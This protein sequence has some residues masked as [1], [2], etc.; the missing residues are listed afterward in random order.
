MK[1]NKKGWYFCSDNGEFALENPENSSYLYFPLANEAGLMSS[2]TPLLHG[3]IKSGQNSFLMAPVSAEELHNSRAGRNFWL[4]VEGFGAWSAAGHSAAQ[5]CMRFRQEDEEYSRLEAGFLWH[6]MTRVNEKMGLEAEITSFVPTDSNR[7]ELMC[8]TVRN[9]GDK[10]VAFT[11][12]AAIP[13]YGRSA[14]NLRDHRHVTSLLNRIYTQQYGITVKPTLSFDERG[15]R[16]NDTVYFVLGADENG[17]APLG[18]YPDVESFIGEGGS[19][20]WPEAIVSNNRE[21]LGPG[22]E[23]GGFE[24]MGALRFADMLLGPGESKSYVVAVGI[25]ENEC[26]AEEYITEYCTLQGFEH[27]LAECRSYW[28]NK[29]G[30]LSFSTGDK[31][32][33]QWMKW[34]TLQPVLRRIYGCSFMPH[35]DYGRGGRGWRDLWQDCLA[36]LLIEPDKVREMLLNNYAGVR[37]DGSN[38]TI[39]GPEPGEFVTDRNSIPRVWMDHGAWPLVTTKLYIDQTGDLGFLL[40]KQ[41]FFKDGNTARCREK[42]TA[43]REEQGSKLRTSSGHIYEGTVLEHILVQNLTAFFNVGEHNNI[44]LEGADWNDAMDMAPQ[45]GE[46]VAFTAFYG[47]NL[48]ELADLVRSLE[49]RLGVHELA[50]SQEMLMLL[51]SLSG[52]IE[53]DSVDAKNMLLDKYFE[54]CKHNI[55]GIRSRVKV[56]DLAEDLERKGRWIIEHLRSSEWIKSS[57]DCQWFNGYYDN[58]GSRLEGDHRN[59]VRMTLTGQV[60]CIMGGIATAEQVEYIIEACRRYLR[61]PGIGGYRLNTDFGELKLNM[62]R[63]FGFAFGHKENGAMFSHMAVMYA[64]ALYKRGH[65][66]EGFEVLDD[67]YRHCSDFEKSRIYPGIP[68]YINERGRGMY[69]YLT[70]SAS[71]LLLTMLTEVFGVKGRLGDLVLEP[72]LLP[73]QFDEAGAAKVITS[74]ANRKIRVSYSNPDKLEFGE[75][76]IRSVMIDGD[77]AV[78]AGGAGKVT[79]KRNMLIALREDVIHDITVELG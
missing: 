2:I 31:A 72:K 46:S 27:K 61:E 20:D 71:W 30:G 59:G 66:G 52:R 49:E 37:I 29:L 22:A 55:S 7:I 11:P 67:I 41:S 34:V 64:N 10:P 74:F 76:G 24:A 19:L 57:G 45:K 54:T 75:Y 17:E 50:I 36:L 8:V 79:I 69:H 5:T 16:K 39:I 65:A 15:H 40:E 47:S 33:D 1:E 43:W 35:H 60:F 42:D 62:G 12:T 28:K 51:D 23:V 56:K 70:G 78:E 26:H 18:F 21:P 6:R 14:D 3:D 73:G 48:M 44:R 4:Y 63:G 25:S 32:F 53:Y 77:I 38:A 68:E 13:V 58:D 9:K